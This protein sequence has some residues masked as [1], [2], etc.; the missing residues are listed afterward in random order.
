MTSLAAALP[1]QLRERISAPPFPEMWVAAFQARLA[2]GERDAVRLYPELLRMVGANDTALEL[3][4][5]AVGASLE[6]AKEAVT[7]RREIEGLDKPAILA[8]MRQQLEAEGYTVLAPE[9]EAGSGG[10]GNGERPHAETI[11]DSATV[12]GHNAQGGG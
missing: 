4:L 2:R 7:M 12:N 11:P 10:A 3:A 5:R 6:F 1:E 8:M 9:S